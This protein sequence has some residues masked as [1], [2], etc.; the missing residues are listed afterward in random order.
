MSLKVLKFAKIVLHS[1]IFCKILI[2]YFDM[3]VTLPNFALLAHMRQNFLQNFRLRR[4]TQF[5]KLSFIVLQ[6]VF[7]TSSNKTKNV[8]KCPTIR[9]S[10]AVDTMSWRMIRTKIWHYGTQIGFRDFIRLFLV[11]IERAMIFFS[12]KVGQDFFN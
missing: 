11:K 10:N 7:P 4:A 6:F 5:G 1:Q 12:K 3:I 8:L 9:F 2:F